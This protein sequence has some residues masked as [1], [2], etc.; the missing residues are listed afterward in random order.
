[1]TTTS[2]SPPSSISVQ[3]RLKLADSLIPRKLI[4]VT[5]E[6][7]RQP[8][9]DRREVDELA[10]VVAAERGGQRGGRR[11]A[12]AHHGEGDDERQQR[13]LERL[14]DVERRA[15]RLRVLGDELGVGGGRERGDH[16]GEREAGPDRA[17]DLSRDLAGPGV[18]AAAE[19]VPDDEQQQ[20]LL[21]DRRAELA[22][23]L[24]LGGGTIRRGR[25]WLTPYPRRSGVKPRA[26]F[27]R[28]GLA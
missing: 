20:H 11:H 15:G 19:D 21:G 23:A 26:R 16:A 6:D 5:T 8:D 28:C 18:D 13:R 12:G 25:P 3:P 4:S 14:V 17:A 10:Q 2:T 22:L 24:G 1:M 27:C 7:H 9:Q